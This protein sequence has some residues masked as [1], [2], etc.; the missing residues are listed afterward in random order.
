MKQHEAI[1]LKII[2]FSIFG[3][4]F[5]NAIFSTVL[6]NSKTISEL[7]RLYGLDTLYIGIFAKVPLCLEYLAKIRKLPF[8]KTFSKVGLVYCL[9]TLGVWQK[10]L[11]LK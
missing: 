8:F 1:I 9:D 11:Y 2:C 4:N 5:E 10:L 3:Q 6:D 7:G